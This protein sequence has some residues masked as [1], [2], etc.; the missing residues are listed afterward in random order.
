MRHS[1]SP[2]AFI[3]A[4]LLVGMTLSHAATATDFLPVPRNASGVQGVDWDLGP[5]PNEITLY[6]VPRDVCIEGYI[7]NFA[8]MPGAPYPVGS[9]DIALD[10]KYESSVDQPLSTG[11]YIRPKQVDC[12]PGPIPLTKTDCIGVD[13]TRPD[14]IM[15]GASVVPSACGIGSSCLCR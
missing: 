3:L 1:R 13:T 10:C 7:A 9:Y 2:I 6:S 11:G 4:A 12:S 15:A 5:G 14:W 8:P